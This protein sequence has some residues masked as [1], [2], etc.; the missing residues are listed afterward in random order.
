MME[1]VNV[2]QTD[3]DGMIVSLIPHLD[4]DA[5]NMKA[6]RRFMDI[7]RRETN[8]TNSEIEV[9]IDDGFYEFD[10]RTVQIVHSTFT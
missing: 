4:D 2:V 6:E 7:L 1:T 3:S 5:G 8:L 9:A 10:G